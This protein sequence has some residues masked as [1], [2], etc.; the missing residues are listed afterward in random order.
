MK[1]ITR[2]ARPAA[3]QD[4][5]D[6]APRAN[7]AFNNGG[8]IEAAPVAFRYSAERYWVAL[9]RGAPGPVAGQLVRLLID[10]GGYFFDLRGLWVRGRLLAAEKPPEVG[11]PDV[12]WFQVVPEKVVTWDY[13]AMRRAADP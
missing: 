3:V 4:L 7:M 2:A 9:S 1:R 13:G 11:S 6:R 12:A 10:D 5:L 8:A